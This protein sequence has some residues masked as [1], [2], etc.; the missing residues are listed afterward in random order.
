MKKYLVFAGSTYYPMGGWNDFR[1]S[2]HSIDEAKNY[3][4]D[5]QK[6]YDWYHIIDSETYRIVYEKYHSPYM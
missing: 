4:L 6:Q 1:T 5:T 3:L 2:F